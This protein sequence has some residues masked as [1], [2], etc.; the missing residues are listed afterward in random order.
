MVYLTI[1][2]SSANLLF[3]RTSIPPDGFWDEP[4]GERC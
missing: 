2:T 1:I 4:E 3:D